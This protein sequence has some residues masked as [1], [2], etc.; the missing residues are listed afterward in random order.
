MSAEA[1]LGNSNDNF[2]GTTRTL[3]HDL[4]ST[5]WCVLVEDRLG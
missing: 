4:T 2:D 3:P 1:A 5:M